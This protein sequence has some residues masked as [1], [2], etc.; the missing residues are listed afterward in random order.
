MISQYSSNH[1]H[2]T[3]DFGEHLMMYWLS[4]NGYECVL[5]RHVGIDIIASKNGERIGISVK[6]RSRKDGASNFSFTMTKPLE[7]IKKIKETC[8]SFACEE[9]FAFVLDQMGIIYG[10]LI[11]LS[12]I[13]KYYSVSAKSSQDWNI[14]KLT[15]DASTISF[16]LNWA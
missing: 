11:P 2:I 12:V 7:H 16:Q 13:E 1:T 5:V 9:Y 10:Y 15:N 14:Q 3:G 4:K 8:S 6:S